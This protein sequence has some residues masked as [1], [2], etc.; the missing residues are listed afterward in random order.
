MISA[1]NE[2][3]GPRRALAP[4][5]AIVGLAVLGCGGRGAAHFDGGGAESESTPVGRL[6]FDVVAT[7]SLSLPAKGTT[8]PTTN[9]FTLVLDPAARRMIAGGGGQ[10]SVVAV[11]S[12]DDRTF[13][14]ATPF[15]V[16][17]AQA[18]CSGLLR[19]EYQTLEVALAGGS[20]TGTATGVATFSSPVTDGSSTVE[21]KSDFSA[22][23]AGVPDVIAPFLLVPAGADTSDPLT[24]FE[25]WASEPL[26]P[27]ATAQLVTADGSRIDLPPQL[28]PGDVPVIAGFSTPD[29][30]LSP[31]EGLQAALDGLT[32]FAG[33][34]VAPGTSLRFGAFDPAPLVPQDGFESA[35]DPTLGG[36][37]VVRT[38][39]GVPIAGAV[40][41]YIGR[42]DSPTPQGL[43]LHPRL[44][45]RLAVPTGATTL[46]FSFRQFSG[47]GDSPGSV[48]IG[49]VGHVPGAPVPISPMPSTAFTTVS[50]F[51]QTFSESSVGTMEVVLPAD[52]TDE[53]V[54]VI[55]SPPACET[56][57]GSP[58]LLIDDLRLE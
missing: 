34:A 56:G 23:L 52:I 46:L 16:G 9:R 12:S 35:M 17:V 8:T 47:S 57:F 18:V 33:H 44:S 11:T 28:V 20:L 2:S 3:A 58:G 39:P 15:A 22:V 25:L 31:G 49:S 4:G 50:W 54:V 7:L 30:A 10:A 43:T 38:G 5:L 53:V 32:D 42:M 45:L 1:S 55:E 41:L 13:A 27:T 21:S 36:A 26:P 40:S 14:S 6:S 48:V 24:P 51:P 29:V 37:A 19:L